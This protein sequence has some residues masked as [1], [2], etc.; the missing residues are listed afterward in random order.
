MSRLPKARTTGIG[1]SGGRTKMTYGIN[2]RKGQFASSPTPIARRTSE[3]AQN[4]LSTTPRTNLGELANSFESITCGGAV[5]SVRQFAGEL[6]SSRSDSR[7][8]E[9]EPGCNSMEKRRNQNGP[10]ESV[11]EH[12]YRK[13]I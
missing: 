7:V 1:T 12:N 9:L 8:G 13:E 4:G 5:E 11:E 6:D 10:E 2:P 3:L